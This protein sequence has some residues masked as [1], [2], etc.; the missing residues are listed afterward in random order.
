MTG[1]LGNTSISVEP[2]SEVTA[3]SAATPSIA[4]QSDATR[5]FKARVSFFMGPGRRFKE[6]EQMSSAFAYP[7]ISRKLHS[8]YVNIHVVDAYTA[9]R[10]R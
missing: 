10:L 1:N 2:G 3:I 8:T 6:Q 7:H 9:V 4:L 5:R